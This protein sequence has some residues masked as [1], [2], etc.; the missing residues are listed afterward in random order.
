MDKFQQEFA[1]MKQLL[2]DTFDGKFTFNYLGEPYYITIIKHLDYDIVKDNC[3][4]GRTIYG[5]TFWRGKT[6]A[7]DFSKF[8]MSRMTVLKYIIQEG[9]SPCMR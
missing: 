3:N 2:L 1:A 4:F 6:D 5:S 7:S 8:I 9:G